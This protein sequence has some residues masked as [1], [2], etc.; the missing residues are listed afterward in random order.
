MCEV[1]LTMTQNYKLDLF[2]LLPFYILL[3]C[4]DLYGKRHCANL[5]SFRVDCCSIELTPMSATRF[6]AFVFMLFGSVV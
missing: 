4:N 1:S 3:L 5:I 2:H 6:S